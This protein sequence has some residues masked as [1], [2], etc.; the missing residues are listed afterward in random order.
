MALAKAAYPV[1]PRKAR[2]RAGEED[3]AFAARQHQ[4]RRF[5]AGE[6]AG[7]AGHFPDLAEHALGRI[8]NRKIDVGADVE[9]A[10][11]ER[12]VLVGIAEEGDDLLLLARIE[13]ARVNFAAG[14]LDLLDQRFELGAVAAP[15]E[16]REALRGELLCD[17]AADEVTG[18]DHGH[19]RV[20]LLQGC[21]PGQVRSV[22]C[23]VRAGLRR[24]ALRLRALQGLRE[25]VLEDLAG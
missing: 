7:I 5:A 3:I 12:R 6:K 18:A 17:L 19:G 11:L 15:G 1:P 14:L 4:A 13:R 2:G 10:D 21:S 23:E 20:S 16:H 22:V 25:L 8:Q 9:D 24:I